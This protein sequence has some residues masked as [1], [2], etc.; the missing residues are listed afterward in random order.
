MEAL[1]TRRLEN[2]LELKKLIREKCSITIKA[3]PLSLRGTLMTQFVVY[4]AGMMIAIVVAL[5]F[6]I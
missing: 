3:I 4:A 6:V 5:Q 2:N 1:C